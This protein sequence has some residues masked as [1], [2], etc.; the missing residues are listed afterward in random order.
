MHG[1]GNCDNENDQ[2]A[3]ADDVEWLA[4]AMHEC[5]AEKQSIVSIMSACMCIGAMTEKPLNY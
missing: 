5:W 3:C 4:D 2:S 1:G